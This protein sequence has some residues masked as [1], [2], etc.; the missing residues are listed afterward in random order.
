MRKNR[1]H[2]DDKRRRTTTAIILALT[3]LGEP[4]TYGQID[5]WLWDNTRNWVRQAPTSNEFGS[6]CAWSDEIEAVG[7]TPVP[8]LSC[9]YSL[10]TLWGLTEW[11]L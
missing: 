5:A 6:L 10:N 7:M 4:S 11:S 2:F 8:S 9:G 3:N 1:I